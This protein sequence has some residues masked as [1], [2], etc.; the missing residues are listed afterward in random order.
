M[1]SLDFALRP[2]LKSVVI[3]VN[4]L[5]AL[6]LNRQDWLMYHWKPSKY[7]PWLLTEIFL[8]ADISEPW[9]WLHFPLQLKAFLCHLIPHW[10]ASGE[11]VNMW[12]FVFL[13]NSWKQKRFFC[14]S[15]CQLSRCWAKLDWNRN[16]DFWMKQS[17]SLSLTHSLSLCLK[18]STTS[19]A[20]INNLILKLVRSSRLAWVSCASSGW[21]KSEDSHTRAVG[22]GQGAR[23]QL[24]GASKPQA[25]GLG[26]GCREGTRQ[27]SERHFRKTPGRLWFMGWTWGAKEKKKWQA[28]HS[29][30]LHQAQVESL[31]GMQ[32]GSSPSIF[33]SIFSSFLSPTSEGIEEEMIEKSQR[34]SFQWLDGESWAGQPFA[35]CELNNEVE[36]KSSKH[37]SVTICF[38][39]IFRD[40]VRKGKHITI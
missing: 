26:G 15:F 2:Y 10:S 17:L 33:S 9:L 27:R 7:P 31:V 29:R 32:V 36:S 13:V 24:P 4:V 11:L 22:D 1:V 5:F 39:L 23:S 18:W 16:R 21:W 14:V 28:I 40:A 6:I 30:M 38:V 19:F 3:C 8:G 20:P 35:T 37:H 12:I 25:V 34:G